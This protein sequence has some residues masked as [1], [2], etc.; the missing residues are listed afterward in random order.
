MQRRSFLRRVLSCLPAVVVGCQGWSIRPRQ[1][2]PEKFAGGWHG[3]AV[4]GHA[5]IGTIGDVFVRGPEYTIV[6]DK[7]PAD[8]SQ[9]KDFHAQQLAIVC[10]ARGIPFDT[11]SGQ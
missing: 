11:V 2:P 1:V 4:I 8:K 10:K 9:H 5:D 3:Y 7:L 6:F